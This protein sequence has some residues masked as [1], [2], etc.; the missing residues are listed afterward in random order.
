MIDRFTQFP[1]YLA[2]RARSLTISGIPTLLAHPDWR[3][4]APFCLW[5][6]GRTAHKELDP[7]RYMRW[8]RAG[9][10]VVA[11]DLP[12][13]GERLEDALQSPAST[14]LVMEQALADVQLTIAAITARSFDGADAFDPAHAA[15]AGM[16]LGGMVALRRLCDPHSFRSAAVEGTAGWLEGMYFPREFQLASPPWPV[17]HARDRV[18]RLDPARHLDRFTPI[19]LLDLHSE[20]DQMVPFEPQKRFIDMLKRHYELRGADPSLVELITW[21]ETGAP[22]EHLGFGRFS[23]DAKN[24]QAAFLA[25]TLGAKSP[26]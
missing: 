9:V 10:G 16:S 4:P 17:D 1:A 15:I 8:L 22:R 19:P 18:A 5:L 13:H 26:A 14:L 12:G 2:H 21:N 23:N 25:R 7:G 3:A 20:Q 24:I 11:I 6:H